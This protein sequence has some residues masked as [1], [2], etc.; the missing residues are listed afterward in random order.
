MKLLVYSAK[1]FEISFMD[2][3][4]KNKHLVTYIKEALNTDTA[5]KAVGFDAISIFS[6]DDASAIVLEKLWDLGVRFITLR[7]AGHNNIHLRV[8]NDFGFKVANAPEY[9][10]FAIAELAVGLLLALNR[11]III[12]NAQVH[13]AN[14]LQE[15]LLGFDLNGKT[16]GI[17]GMGNIGS[18]MAKIM[19]GFGCTLLVND[20][21]PNL[22]LIQK[23]R[24]SNV[25]LEELCSRSDVVSLHVPLTQETHYMIDDTI[26]KRMKKEVILINTARGAVVDTKTLISALESGQI[27]G[28]GTDVYE[29]ERGTFF[30]DHSKDGIQDVQLKK[31]LSFPNVLL[32]PHQGFITKEALTN[33]AETTFYNLDRWSGGKTSKNELS[34][35]ITVL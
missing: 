30:Q 10:P 13:N 19:Q 4:N 2:V 9:S 16:V 12:A 26:F 23:Y 20:I 35:E 11:K 24:M 28:Y 21:E 33:I 34:H 31:L 5:I 22:D 29:K 8:A 7:S 25:S 15:G 27:G 18:V 32:T 14:F 1:D 3:A 17:V 6:G